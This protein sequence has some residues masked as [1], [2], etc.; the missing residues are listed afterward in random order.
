[1]KFLNVLKAILASDLLLPL[2]LLLTYIV[3]LVIARGIVPTSA[4]LVNDF[5]AL[6]LKYGYEIIF[7]AAFLES[8]ILINLFVPGGGAMAL[9][10]VFAR[11]GQT[12]LIWVILAGGTGAICGYIIDYILGYYGFADILKKAGYNNLL[13]EAK[14]KLNKF[15]KRGLILGFINPNIA[16]FLALAAGTTNFNKKYFVILAICATFFWGTLWASLVYTLGDIFL[17]FFKNYSFLLIIL[18]ILGLVLARIWKGGEH[19]NVRS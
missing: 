8:L 13:N 10:A 18:I 15:G 11:T 14:N 12:Q 2:I 19:K 9:G 17:D 16:S 3:F 7:I 4:E 5:Q 1:M 6:Y